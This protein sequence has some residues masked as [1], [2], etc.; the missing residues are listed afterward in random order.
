MDRT[1][2]PETGSLADRAT[3]WCS[4]VNAG[5]ASHCN[6]NLRA[7]TAWQCIMLLAAVFH[8]RQTAFPKMTTATGVNRPEVALFHL[9]PPV[10]GHTHL[11]TP[12]RQ[13]FQGENAAHLRVHPP[14]VPA[15][16]GLAHAPPGM[17]H[18]QRPAPLAR[19]VRCCLPQEERLSVYGLAGSQEQHE[20]VVAH[21]LTCLSRWL[22]S[23]NPVRKALRRFASGFT[24][25]PAEAHKP[26]RTHR[27]TAVAVPSTP[28]LEPGPALCGGPLSAT[29]PASPHLCAPAC[30]RASSR[31]CYRFHL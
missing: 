11:R 28:W 23:Y 20:L 26:S 15:P 8:Q 3:H 4:I 27:H 17:P 10:S 2:E 9:F 6:S 1:F 29:S 18:R 19:S 13:R 25:M 21:E 12:R 31:W 14:D 30:A 7:G 22:P 24:L 16:G 5:G